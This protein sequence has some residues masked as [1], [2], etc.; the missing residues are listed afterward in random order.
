MAIHQAKKAPVAKVLAVAQELNMQDLE[1]VIDNLLALRAQRSGR[2]MPKEEVALLEKINK[3][4]APE[5]FRRFEI[6]DA[7]RRN[8]TLSS[9][10]HAELIALTEAMEQLDAQRIKYLTK[11]AQLRKITLRELMAQIG[12]RNTQ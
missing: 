6:L 5:K 1:S 3:G 12:L 7:K 9:Q 4:L 11:L 8:E 10:E 2:A